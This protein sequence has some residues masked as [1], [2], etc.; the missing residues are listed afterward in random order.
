MRSSYEY[1]NYLLVV[2]L[3]RR[4]PNRLKSRFLDASNEDKPSCQAIPTKFS[5]AQFEEV[6]MPHLSRG[7]RGPPPTLSLHKILN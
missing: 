4:T 5:K 1:M 2:Q 3:I 6:V 7:R